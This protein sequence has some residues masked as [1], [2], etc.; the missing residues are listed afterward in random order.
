MSSE[1]KI[2]THVKFES[3]YGPQTG[4]VIDLIKCIANGQ[5]HATIEVD[6]EL[7]GI[8]WAIPLAGLQLAD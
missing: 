5:P 3:D 8:V 4:Y 6:H 1:I 7:H 2:G